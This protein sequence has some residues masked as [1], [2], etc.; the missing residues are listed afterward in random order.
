[1]QRLSSRINTMALL[2][3]ESRASPIQ[4]IQGLLLLCVWPVPIN[5]AQKDISH[6]LSGAAMTLATQIGLHV[7]GTGQE[8]ARVKLD[9]NRSQNLFRAQLW[10]HSVMICNRLFLNPTAINI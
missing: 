1:M 6:V 9:S 7:T 8:F 5:T 3:L 2:S 10:I 4:T